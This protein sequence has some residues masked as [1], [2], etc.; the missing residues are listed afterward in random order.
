M[1]LTQCAVCGAELPL[2]GG[3]G[4]PPTYCSAHRK[5][6]MEYRRQ[7]ERTVDVW[8]PDD[9]LAAELAALAP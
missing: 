1:R 5:G 2:R 4:R 7:R 6:V 3:P 8:L 9:E